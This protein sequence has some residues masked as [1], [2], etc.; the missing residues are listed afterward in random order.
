MGSGLTKYVVWNWPGLTGGGRGLY[1]E[2]V[3][4]A[5]VGKTLRKG[6]VF[7][8]SVPFHFKKGQ[9]PN[10]LMKSYGER[11]QTLQSIKLST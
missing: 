8:S 10:G 2:R 1:V 5:V 11:A 7:I 6:L 4:T 9:G 3:R